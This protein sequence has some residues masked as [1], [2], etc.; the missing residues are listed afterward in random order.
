MLSAKALSD[1]VAVAE[2]QPT[3]ARLKATNVLS[4][5][6]FAFGLLLLA[7]DETVV[8]S[9][10]FAAFIYCQACKGHLCILQVALRGLPLLAVA[11]ALGCALG[12][13]ATDLPWGATQIRFA[14][15]Q[16]WLRYNNLN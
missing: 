12:L 15:E 5:C 3:P 14:M 8:F 11:A 6:N 2:S 13:A 10:S 9:R 16:P 7:A 4:C 1:S